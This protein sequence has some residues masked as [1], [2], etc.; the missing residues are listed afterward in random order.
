MAEA[1]ARGRGRCG[2]C[3]RRDS[4]PRPPPRPTRVSPGGRTRSIRPSSIRSAVSTCATWS[5]SSRDRLRRSSS[6]AA[7]S[8][9]DSSR[10]GA[11]PPARSPAARPSGAR[12]PAAGTPRAAPPPSPSRT[13]CQQQPIQVVV[14]CGL[15][16]RH[17]G[18]LRSQ[19]RVVQL[20]DLLRDRQH[21]LAPR[22]HL[23]PQKRRRSGGSSRSA[24]SRTAGRT[25]PSSRRAGP[26]ADDARPGR[27]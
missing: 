8:C 23:A 6:C 16:P 5:C 20:L 15:P 14:Q 19:V 12:G 17:F 27:P 1:R 21:G 11:R 25:S 13:V 9:C 24:S 3:C 4:W 26:G 2:T 7:T 18:A 22:H 10:I